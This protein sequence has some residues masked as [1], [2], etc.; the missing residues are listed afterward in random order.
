MIAKLFSLAFISTI[1]ASVTIPTE[2]QDEQTT[3]PGA[4]FASLKR[5]SLN[6][7]MQL[8]APLLAN[9]IL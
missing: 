6:N 3:Y 1:A 5:S 2:F 4:I 9:E 8:M 7:I